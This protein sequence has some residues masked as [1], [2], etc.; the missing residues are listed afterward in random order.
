M[1]RYKIVSTIGDGAYGLV[2]KAV[3]N[4]TGDTVAVKKMKRKFYNWQECMELREIKSLK[5]LSHPNIIKLKEVIRENDELFFVFEYAEGNLYQLMSGTQKSL[6]EMS[7]RSVMSQ[8][9]NGLTYMHKHGFFHRDLKPENL[10]VNGG[11]VL[12]HPHQGEAA[13]KLADFGLAREIRS[14]PPFTDYVSTRWYRAP[15]VL[16]RSTNY[17]SPIDLWAAGIIMAELYLMRPLFPGTSET[18]E[19]FKICSVLGTPTP[20]QWPEG[21]RLAAVMSFKFPQMVPTP[22]STLIPAASN[23]ALSLMNQLLVWDPKK[24]LTAQEAQQH[25]FFTSCLHS[26]K[27]NTPG[28]LAPLGS[29]PSSGPTGGYPH[30]AARQDDQQ[31]CAGQQAMTHAGADG[32]RQGGAKPAGEAP[33]SRWYQEQGR[34]MSSDYY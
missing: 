15:E 22:L 17:N 26:A 8:V 3:Q 4:E 27:P 34:K 18:D 10:L 7:I 2:M 13:L 31:F 9:Y 16:L 23:E 28:N 24:R 19:I 25:S 21:Q 30:P 32:M 11:E 14:R 33:G 12:H 6:P 5:K 20:Q 1:H 29:T